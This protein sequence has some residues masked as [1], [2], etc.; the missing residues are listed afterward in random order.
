MICRATNNCATI[1]RFR[2]QTLIATVTVL[3]SR[4][5]QLLLEM[6][7]SSNVLLAFDYDGT[8]APLVNAPARATMRASTRRLLVHA[9]KLYPCVVITG[10]AQADVT[11]PA[12]VT[13]RCGSWA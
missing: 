7:A 8:L 10:R 6:F 9:S 3:F 12:F 13:S 4:S 1:N 5:H 11:R 2:R